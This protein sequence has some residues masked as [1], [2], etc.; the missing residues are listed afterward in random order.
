MKKV[1]AVVAGA[2]LRGMEAYAVYALEHPEELEIVAVAEP[3][4]ARREKFATDHH[5]PPERVFTTWEDLLAQPRLADAALICTQ[6]RMHYAPVLAA[7][8]KGY[9]VLCEKP[10]SPNKQEILAMGQAAEKAGRILSICHV[11]RYSPFFRQ[12]KKLLDA[13]TIGQ[14]VSIQAME[15]V[16][17][18]HAAHSFVRGNWRN[19]QE[20]SPM[21]LQKCCHD[22]DIYTWLLGKKCKAISS[23]GDT[24]LFKK[25]CAPE[26]ATPYCLGG[27]KAK[28][29]CKFDA[30]KIYITNPATGI[31]NGNTWMAGVACGVNP[32]EERTY[33]ALKN[34]QYGRCVY[35]CD[36]NVVDHQQ[37]NLLFE[38]GTT[39]SFTMCAFTEKCYRYFKAM[40][41]NGEIEA[42]MLSN[43]IHVRVFGEPEE[44]IDVK[45]LANDLKGHGGGDSGI[46]NDF[47]DML[48][49][50]TEATERTTTLEHSLE[51]HF[52]ALAAEESR[53][54]GG[55]L[56]NMDAFK[57]GK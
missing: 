53:L 35:M 32:T 24:H 47:L 20:T 21:I 54:R 55:E 4:P 42:D 56:I 22:M 7:L 38:D 52:M 36:N 26:G 57:N 31:R 41:T 3:N 48:I 13:G 5:L 50:E 44:I 10:M 40:G 33:E 19:S 39:M 1:T 17:Y 28:E 2:G 27:C 23:V 6:D 25:E 12:L 46:V 16:G 37:T 43:K 51:S 30:E 49:N 34:G 8:D 11:L 15:G 14:L 29:N 9:H 18:Y 45:L